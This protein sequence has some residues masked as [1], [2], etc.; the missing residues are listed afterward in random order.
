MA[1]LTDL[2]D[3]WHLKFLSGRELHY[4]RFPSRAAAVAGIKGWLQQVGGCGGLADSLCDINARALNMPI[5]V[6][7]FWQI[8]NGYNLQQHELL[9]SA[10]FVLLLAFGFCHRKKWWWAQG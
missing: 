6:H 5:R 4:G 9:H 1:I 7:S 8:Y 10:S 3:E 2:V